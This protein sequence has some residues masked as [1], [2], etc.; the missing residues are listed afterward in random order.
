[1]KTLAAL[2]ALTVI[3]T[4]DA[5]IAD[6]VEAD[7]YTVQLAKLINDYR[8]QRGLQRLAL[9]A[10]LSELAHEHAMRMAQ[11]HRLS[12]DGFQQRFAKARAQTCVE[13]V[14]SNY[15]TPAAE[16]EA[17][18]KSPIHDRNLLDTRITQMGL[19]I[20]AG[21]VTFFACS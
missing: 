1:M 8:A 6:A 5:V 13:N 18:R 10:P 19:A 20:E 9:T 15:A 4:S 11:Q 12:H 3:A 2:V 7:G 17:W 21:Y 14:G 16:F